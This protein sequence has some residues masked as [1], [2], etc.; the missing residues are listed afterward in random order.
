MWVGCDVLR[1]GPVSNLSQTNRV[2]LRVSEQASIERFLLHS[3]ENNNF[4]AT[5]CPSQTINLYALMSMLTCIFHKLHKQLVPM[6]LLV[7]RFFVPL[8]LRPRCSPRGGRV[9][10]PTPKAAR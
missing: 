3:I 5:P 4:R 7:Q 6:P 1:G 8:V 9:D 10:E 2:R